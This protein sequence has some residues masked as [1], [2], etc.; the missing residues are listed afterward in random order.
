MFHQSLLLD[1]NEFFFKSVSRIKV[2]TLSKFK[3]TVINRHNLESE[4]HS[5]EQLFHI[6]WKLFSSKYK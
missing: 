5:V 6:T 2:K 3:A 4:N 1:L